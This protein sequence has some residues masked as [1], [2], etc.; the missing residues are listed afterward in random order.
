MGHFQKQEIDANSM[1]KLQKA[2]EHH[3][4]LHTQNTWLSIREKP[5]RSFHDMKQEQQPPDCTGR[6][7]ED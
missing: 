5:P 1:L 7:Q 2:L 3:H 6:I 4:V